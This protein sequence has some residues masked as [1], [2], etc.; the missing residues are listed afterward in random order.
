MAK[1]DTVA[2]KRDNYK[3]LINKVDFIE[4]V[5]I[6][7]EPDADAE[8]DVEVKADF[9]VEVEAEVETK[10]AEIVSPANA[11]RDRIAKLLKKKK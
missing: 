7:W 3:V 6:P 2:I 8:A 9:E 4:G 11:E 5:H 10:E 1:V